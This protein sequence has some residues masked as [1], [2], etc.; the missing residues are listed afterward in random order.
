MTFWTDPIGLIDAWLYGVLVGWGLSSEVSRVLL[1]IV[2][3]FTLATGAM[4]F[5]VF[6]IWLERKL[7]GRFQDR[8][9]PNRVGPFGIFQTIADML[10]IFTK[11][12]ITPDGADRIPY[13]LGP[14]LAVAGVLLVYAVLPFGINF[15]GVNLDMGALYVVAAGTIGELGIILAGWGSNNKYALLGAFRAI[16]QLISYEVPMLLTLLIP[17]M[18][19]GSMGLNTIVKAQNPWFIIYA[20]LAGLIFFISLVAENARAPFDLVEADSELV[21]GFN[22]EYSGLKFGMFYVAEFLH[23]FTNS[24]LFAVLFLGGWQGPGAETYPWLG[25]LYTILKTSVV[26]F[27]ILTLRAG[28]PRFRIDQ[29]M[30]INWKLLTPFSM[31]ILVVTAVVDKSLM[32]SSMTG[33][34]LGLLA[35]NLVLLLVALRFLRNYAQKRRRPLVVPTASIVLPDRIDE[36]LS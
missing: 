32:Q 4:I 20:P 1:Y 3:A 30:D 34:I 24:V 19:S 16:G 25:L 28:L 35:A 5:T 21:A 31:A 36:V 7:I 10:K 18:L 6:L 33:R 11:E 8:F 9:G 23:A 17:V 13:N 29:V 15:L 2:G 27:A 14:V 12:F 22:I 26:F